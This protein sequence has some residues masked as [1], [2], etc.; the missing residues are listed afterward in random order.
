MKFFSRVQIKIWFV[1]DF[2]D[3]CANAELNKLQPFEGKKVI[4]PWLKIK[5]TKEQYVSFD[6]YLIA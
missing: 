1:V 2:F 3:F 6:V 5:Q 4:T